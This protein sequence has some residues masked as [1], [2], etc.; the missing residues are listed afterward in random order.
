MKT[1]HMKYKIL[2]AMLF[3]CIFIQLDFVLEAVLSDFVHVLIISISLVIMSVLKF[4][5]SPHLSYESIVLKLLQFNRLHVDDLDLREQIDF[6]Q[7]SST[8][9]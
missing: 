3:H 2:N 5:S 1:Q 9:L 7:I 8:Q 6:D 4:G